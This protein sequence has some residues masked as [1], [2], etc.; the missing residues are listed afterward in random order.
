MANSPAGAKRREGTY[1]SWWSMTSVPRKA[2]TVA[3][4]DVVMTISANT[5]KTTESVPWMKVLRTT[6]SMAGTDFAAPKLVFPAASASWN[7]RCCA[8]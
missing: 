3:S 5:R 4:T 6:A 1:G 8:Q 2:R 7:A